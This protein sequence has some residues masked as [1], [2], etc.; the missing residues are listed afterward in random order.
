MIFDDREEHVVMS[1]VVRKAL[2]SMGNAFIMAD[3]R[4]AK[5]PI[6]RAKLN[7]TAFVGPTAEDSLAR[8]KDVQKS[9][10]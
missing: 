1:M 6:A 9:R 3:S 5:S 2:N 7:A 8:Q 4:N 10:P